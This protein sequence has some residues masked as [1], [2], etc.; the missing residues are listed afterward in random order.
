MFDPVQSVLPHI[1]SGRL[2]AI[3]VTSKQ[4]LSVL[5]DV[6]TVAESGYA[7]Y[8]M[9]AWWGV[10]APANLPK[11]I[12]EKLT[13]AVQK[14]MESDSF[15]R[16]GDLGIELSYMDPGTFGKFIETESIK[17]SKVVRES[18]ATLD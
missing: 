8:E 18:S 12:L 3:A 4:R 13:A 11:P 10:L 6:P 1:K 2:K 15:K 5:P 7:D 14:A 17:W 16:L 9:T